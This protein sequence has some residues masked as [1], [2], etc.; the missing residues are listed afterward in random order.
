MQTPR[1]EWSPLNVRDKEEY[2]DWFIWA[3]YLVITIDLLVTAIFSKRYGIEGELNPIVGLLFEIGLAYVVIAN[4][5]VVI[6]AAICFLVLLEAFDS[7]DG[8][9]SVSSPEI[10]GRPVIVLLDVWIGLLFASG[11]FVFTNNVL[12]LLEAPS[13]IYVILNF[14]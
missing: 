12:V 13:L 3:V 8:V 11:L 14:I 7:A 6:F 1:I 5:L 9:F 4:I 10:H 2:W